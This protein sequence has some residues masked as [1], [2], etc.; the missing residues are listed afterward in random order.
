M[1][2][3]ICEI[4]SEMKEMDFHCNI[5][6]STFSNQTLLAKHIKGSH[7]QL[8]SGHTIPPD[9]WTH[10]NAQSRAVGGPENQHVPRADTQ[11]TE[12]VGNNSN[13]W[14]MNSKEVGRPQIFLIP[15]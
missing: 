12:P 4:S 7:R 13:A 1:P 14:Y 11:G 6:G 5:C 10:L 2:D 15:R 8:W 3:V 9:L